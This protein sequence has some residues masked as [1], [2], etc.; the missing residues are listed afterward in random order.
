MQEIGAGDILAVPLPGREGGIAY[1]PVTRMPIPTKGAEEQF[2]PTG[3][4]PPPI[5]SKEGRRKFE[6]Q[7]AERA[8]ERRKRELVVTEQMVRDGVLVSRAINPEEIELFK[9]GQYMDRDTDTV[10]NLPED[11][12]PRIV[13][14]ELPEDLKRIVAEEA[15]RVQ[16]RELRKPPT[17]GTVA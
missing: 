3:E 6:K 15:G 7:R 10:K 1:Y 17:P 13:L 14:A 16:V 9:K 4:L 8:E 11:R 5:V 12:I 2:Q